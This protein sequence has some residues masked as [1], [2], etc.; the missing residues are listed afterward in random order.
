MRKQDRIDQ[1]RN[2]NPHEPQSE[3]KPRPP[4]NEQVK[5]SASTEHPDKPPRQPGKMPLPD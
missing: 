1:E 4:V 5:G 2:Q 3:P